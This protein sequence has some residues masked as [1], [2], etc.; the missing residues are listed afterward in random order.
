MS[1]QTRRGLVCKCSYIFYYNLYL[2][3][4]APSRYT[5]PL[6]FQISIKLMIAH[7]VGAQRSEDSALLMFMSLPSGF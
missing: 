4:H 2:S 6:L 7:E 1:V 5:H 3:H